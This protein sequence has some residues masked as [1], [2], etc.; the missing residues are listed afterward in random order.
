VR[1]AVGP[2]SPKWSPLGD[3]ILFRAALPFDPS[4]PIC[5]N[6]IE[7]WLYDLA[8]GELV[9]VTSNDEAEFESSWEGPN[10]LPDDLEVTVD[11]VTITF[12]D[13]TGAGVTTI[14][15]DDDPPE[16]PTGYLFDYE[17]FQLNTTAQTT[18]PATICMSYEQSDVP[19][20]QAEEQLAIL[21][22]NAGLQ[23]WEDITTSRDPAANIVC[24]Q[25]DTLSPVALYGVRKT[26][27][28]DVPAWGYGVAGLDPY[29]AYYQVMAC[30]QAGIV[31]GYDDGTYQPTSTVTRDQTAVYLARALA[32]GDGDVPEGPETA[33]FADV[34]GDHWAYRH[35]EY[36]A[37]QNVVKG[38]EDGTYRP[39]VP[40]D[41]GQ[42]AV[43]VA[44]AMVAPG[45]DAAIPD[46][47]ATA[48][49]PDVP[50]TFWAYKQVEYCV[51]HGVVNGYEDGLYHPEIIVT[52]DQMA[53]YIARA[54]GL[55]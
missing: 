9:Q 52:R 25:T 54:F 46:P 14:L 18:G 28:S 31:A 15:R 22:Y 4:G 16:V 21:H 29:W 1:D 12:S 53:V 48:S 50:D 7:L 43:Y 34:A 32:G 20:G 10:T 17:F 13:V 3:R 41:R 26:R 5:T 35:I 19:E 6:Q 49:F 39:D 45:G 42:M 11:N 47:S 44:R 24:G 36:A 8:S 55:L 51:E 23:R 27:F 40:V 37:S 30:V 33:T 2:S 38:Y